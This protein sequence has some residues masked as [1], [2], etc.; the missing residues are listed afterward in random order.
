MGVYSD[1]GKVNF[2]TPHGLR[3]RL[4]QQY[5]FCQLAEYRIAKDSTLCDTD[6][7]IVYSDWLFANRIIEYLFAAPSMLLWISAV[8]SVVWH[9]R[10]FDFCVFSTAAYA[11]GCF[12]KLINSFSLTD[13]IPY[14]ISRVYVSLSFVPLIV[15]AVL[16]F[17]LDGVY[18]IVPYI[19]MRLVLGAISL[20][21]NSVVSSLAYRKYGV[22]FNDTEILALGVFHHLTHSHEK[23]DNYVGEYVSAVLK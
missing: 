3:V 21:I 7:E 16:F 14:A 6:G 2:T 5:F 9:L 4:D 19:V 15:L 18:L 12:W 8:L 11:L 20:M 17:T 22:P 10:V 23:F 1:F 13:L